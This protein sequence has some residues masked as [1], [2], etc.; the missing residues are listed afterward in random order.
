MKE[1]DAILDMG[2]NLSLSLWWF[3]NNTT[4]KDFDEMREHITRP[5]LR[6]KRPQR[7]LE[8][9][10]SSQFPLAFERRID[11]LTARTAPRRTPGGLGRNH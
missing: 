1:I 6:P 5:R 8:R 10:I 7:G 2:C 11:I 4:E 9:T 3:Q